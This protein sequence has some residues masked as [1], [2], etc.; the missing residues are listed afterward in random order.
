MR[1]WPSALA[2]VRWNLLHLL[3]RCHQHR[4]LQ[5]LLRAGGP[6]GYSEVRWLLHEERLAPECGDGF[7]VTGGCSQAGDALSFLCC[8]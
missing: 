8:S 2:S 5:Q 3:L 6:A 4:A 1:E 7:L